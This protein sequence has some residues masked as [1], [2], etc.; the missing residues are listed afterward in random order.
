MAIK[1]KRKPLSEVQKQERRERLALAREK[2]AKPKYISVAANVRELEDEDPLSL[3]NTRKHIKTNK[4]E[5][6]R[7]RIV[8]RRS[9]D[10]K[11]LDRFHIVDT[12]IQNMEYYL[13]NGIW[14]DL[15]YGEQQEN[16]V[17]FKSHVLAYD[18]DGMMKRT[19][20]CFYPDIGGLY[21]QEMQNTDMGV[22]DKVVRKRA[23]KKK[24]KSLLT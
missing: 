7:L 12:Y 10:R 1:K 6:Q 18:S 17:G 5:R 20:N 15:F 23:K 4:D 11:T 19:V 21:T 14:L 13:R 24:K 2:K 22:F 9:T 3:K 16:K 8:L